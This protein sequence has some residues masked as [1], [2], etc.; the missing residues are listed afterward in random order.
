MKLSNALKQVVTTLK[1]YV[2]TLVSNKQDKNMIVNVTKTTAEDG[3]VTYSADKTFEEIKVTINNGIDVFVKSNNVIYEL[4]KLTN[5]NVQFTS[6][7]ASSMLYQKIVIKSDDIVTYTA[8]NVVASENIYGGVKASAKSDI[9]TVEAKIGT[10]GKLYV[11]EY[12]IVN[13]YTQEEIDNMEFITIDDIDEI[14][15]GV[16]EGAI[17]REDI[18][19]LLSKLEGK[20]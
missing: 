11:P 18:N 1:K 8:I 9:D 3:T 5:S 19:E 15:G 13:S 2:D 6:Y 4:L 7:T 14:C 17:P 20:V 10:D 12:P 16:T